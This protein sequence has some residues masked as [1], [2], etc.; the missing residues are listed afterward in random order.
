MSEDLKVI[1]RD[2]TS[3]VLDLS[4]I[5]KVT[6]PATD[7][8]E[9]T[10]S[11]ELMDD[12]NIKFYNGMSTTEI[13]QAIIKTAAGKIT[14]NKPK[15]T[16][17]AARLSLY[18]IYHRVNMVLDEMTLEATVKY[19]IEEG[20]YNPAISEGFNLMLLESAVVLGRDNKFNYNG[21]LSLEKRYLQKDSDGKVF[22]TPQY[23][24]MMVSMFLASRE[25]VEDKNQQAIKFYDMLSN[26]KA[27]TATPTLS[28][29]RKI[30]PQLSSCFLLSLPDNIEGIFD[31]YKEIGILSKFGGG[32]GADATLIRAAGSEI[33]NN[34]GAA[35]GIIPTIKVIDSMTSFVDQLGVRPSAIAIYLE[36]WHLDIEDFLDVS[37]TSGD[38]RR[39]TPDLFPAIWAN[40]LFMDRVRT[41]EDWTL[42]DP[43]ETPE[44]HYL[45]NEEFN[46]RYTELEASDSIRK[47]VVSAKKL[48]GKIISI[49]Y[50]TGIPFVTFKDEFNRR[51]PN[52]G[53]G[54]I[55]SSNLCVTGDTILATSEGLVTCKELFD[56][57]NKLLTTYDDRVNGDARTL[58]VYTAAS[59]EMHLTKKNAEIFKV[60]TA[61]G[62]TIKSTH[63]HEYYIE[64]DMSVSKKSLKELGVG[65]KLLL[66]SGIGQFTDNGTFGEGYILGLISSRGISS[67]DN[68]TISLP[69]DEIELQ[70]YLERYLDDIIGSKHYI[71]SDESSHV[72]YNS[73]RLYYAMSKE[74]DV[75]LSSL[76]EK[77]KDF[78][79]GYLTTMFVES[80]TS[81]TVSKGE[82]VS[83]TLSGL[84]SAQEYRTLQIILS[85]FGI[86]ATVKKYS[87]TLSDS[88]LQVFVDLIG[89]TGTIEDRYKRFLNTFDIAE[90]KEMP[91]TSEI[92]SI[93]PIGTEDVYDTTQL[94]NHSLI[95]NGLVT[96]NCT[97]IGSA[98]K[99]SEL[100]TEVTTDKGMTTYNENESITTDAGITKRVAR[101][102]SGDIVEGNRVQF[103][104]NKTKDGA[105]QVCNL[106]SINLGQVKDLSDLDELVPTAIRALNNVV[107]LNFFPN[108]KTY[109]ATMESRNIA[110]GTMG[111]HD[112]LASRSVMYGS[113]EALELTDEL[114]EKISF[115]AIKASMELA[116]ERGAYNALKGS[117][118]S[119]GILPIDTANEKAKELT[120]R[121]YTQDWDW[122]RG[123]VKVHGVYNGTIMAIAPTSSISIIC[124]A[125]SSIEPIFKRFFVEDTKT[126]LIPSVI[127]DLNAS[128]W[129]YYQPQFDVEQEA[130]IETTAVA[131]K[132]IDQSISTSLYIRSDR[133]SGKYVAGLYLLA[134]ELGLKSVYYCKTQSAEEADNE[135]KSNDYAECVGCQ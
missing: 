94:V 46:K 51:N 47:K 32:V 14:E 96:G 74:I 111:L 114:F 56:R 53:V 42:F 34:K 23:M 58:G 78:Q 134:E 7:G 61:S 1:K 72:V 86:L 130:I 106:L 33:D 97:E 101:L 73:T 55:L 30:R 25:K 117:D 8:L 107:D 87:L 93:M 67:K 38:E 62:H 24:L 133:A 48:F 81:F 121:V 90:L 75:G 26:L 45:H 91:F 68:T 40:K 95:F 109:T 41:E 29:A 124:N 116:K 76:L 19:G 65:D 89:F 27:M 79:T 54:P 119:K 112:Y 31:I 85:N 22:E 12:A 132:W 80:N 57:G 92:V 11:K 35:G 88:H 13:H 9:F 105:T 104:E 63:Y 100:V 71:S 44:L 127:S 39:R 64:E 17:V 99:P 15:W 131:Q 98:A 115:L 129:K 69:V 70:L 36:P 120:T 3:E 135:T 84:S 18:S 110:L 113:P 52:A 82:S 128:N 37:K 103:I 10:S 16:F 5:T 66:Q 50:A 49:A 125:S 60:V 108:K 83:V 77:S 126:G 4:K 59:I 2:G 20:V 122:L 6:I 21:V 102:N 43:Y 118:W 123:E 28:S